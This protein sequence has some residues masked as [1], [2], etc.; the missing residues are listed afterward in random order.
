MSLRGFGTQTLTGTPQ[1]L[2]GTTLSAAVIPSPDLY[3]GRLDPGSQNSSTIL[4]LNAPV[5]LFRQG[6]HV[7][8]GASNTFIQGNTTPVDGGTVQSI[9]LT[10]SNVIVTGLMRKHSASEWVVLAMPISQALVQV[11]ASNTG[12]Q[13]YLGED[14]TVASNSQT[15]IA[16]IPKNTIMPPFSIP[17]SAGGTLNTF[18]SQK[19]WVVGTASDTFLPSLLI[20]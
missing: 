6:D 12:A 14:P 20:V 9:N 1:P 11:S 16:A 4:P 18:D 10:A 17:M 2:I 8:V 5:Y 7:M 3:T 13:I 19:M 15:L